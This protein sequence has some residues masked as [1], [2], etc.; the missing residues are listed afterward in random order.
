ML[1]DFV[2]VS[3]FHCSSFFISRLRML[4]A[5]LSHGFY[6]TFVLI[7]TPLSNLQRTS[8]CFSGV[9][10][11]F[12]K[13]CRF[14]PV[15]LQRYVIL[16]KNKKPDSCESGFSGVGIKSLLLYPT[17]RHSYPDSHRLL[18]ISFFTVIICAKSC[19]HFF[20]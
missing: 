15:F 3:T 9:I 19:H 20:F 13:I 2:P 11:V 18:L 7:F 17:F 12:H 4:H 1:P 6:Q 5:I 10:T 16:Y 8:T 14:I